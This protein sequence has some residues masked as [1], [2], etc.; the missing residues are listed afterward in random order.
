MPPATGF[1]KF[2]ENRWRT[3]FHVIV[4][5]NGGRLDFRKRRFSLAIF[6]SLSKFP[7]TI[8]VFSDP[9]VNLIRCVRAEIADRHGAVAAW[10]EPGIMRIGADP[11]PSSC[12]NIRRSCSSA[13][14]FLPWRGTEHPE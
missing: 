14:I 3:E 11:R 13:P 10:S 6:R 8:F 7:A 12:L 1:N 4:Q 9:R 2:A 5:G